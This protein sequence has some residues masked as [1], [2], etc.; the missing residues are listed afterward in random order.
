MARTA[1]EDAR[2]GLITKRLDSLAQQK[3]EL[4]GIAALYRAMLPLLAEAQAGVEPFILGTETARRK[5]A[6]GLPLLPGENLPLDPAAT[7]SLFIRLCRLVEGQTKQGLRSLFNLRQAAPVQLL[8]QAY[9]G[10]DAVVRAAAARQI[11]QAVD[12]SYLDL[13]AVWSALAAGDTQAVK[14]LARPLKLDSGLLQTLAQNSLKPALRVW[15][16][17]AAAEVELDRWGRGQCPVCGSPPALSEIQGK[18]G[19]RRLRCGLCGAGWSYPRLKCAFCG[20]DDYKSLGYLVV[21]GEEEKYRLQ[22]CGACGNYIKVVVTFEPTPA[23]L[24]PVEE[25]A[26]LHLDEIARERGWGARS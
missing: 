23:D 22:T 10:N 21:E 6:A 7:R 8:E 9:N 17:G 2:A 1:V 12:R 5:L 15:A 20:L 19:A 26:T 13:P 24:L 25:L 14:L 16:Q 18:E 3:P 4:A 11:R